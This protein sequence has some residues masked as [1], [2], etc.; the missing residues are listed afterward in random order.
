M[1]MENFIC[2]TCGAQYATNEAPPEHCIICEDER[3]YIGWN[4][5]QW[6]TLAE[7]KAAGHRNEFRELEPNLIGIATKPTFAIGQIAIL[8]RTPRG[9]ALW[10][11]VSHIDDETIERVNELGG[12]QAIGV[13]HPHFYSSIV[14]WSHAFGNVPIFIPHAD[15]EWAVRPDPVIKFWEGTEEIVPGVTLIQCGGHFEGSAVVHWAEGAGGHGA[16]LVG[17]TIAVAQDRRHASFMRSYP[18]LIPL[19]ASAIQHIVEAV[20][21]YEFDRMYGAWW[22]RVISEGA[23]E[24]VERS[25]ERYIRYTQAEYSAAG[26][27]VK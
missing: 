4:G 24:A 19:P 8:V 15:K 9:N 6:T 12:I 16:L 10:D 2:K 5:Q 20:R 18:N 27:A 11:C 7:L 17:D 26:F 13:S 22:G 21:P 14:E 25:A 23:K 3:Q 1:A